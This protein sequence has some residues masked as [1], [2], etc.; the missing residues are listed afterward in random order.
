MTKRQK[1]CGGAVR[2]LRSGAVSFRASAT[3]LGLGIM[4]SL[5]ACGSSRTQIQRDTRFTEEHAKVFEDG[6]DFVTDPEQ[7][8]GRWRKEWSRE[9]DKRVRFSDAIARVTIHTL[10][11]DISPKGG[12]TYRLIAEV[13]KTFVG[14]LPEDEIMLTVSEGAR[15]YPTIEGNDD[16]I[17]QESY[18]VF[19]KWYENEDGKVAP[20]WH[21]SPT[22]EPV[23][24]RLKWLIEDRRD[25]ALEDE[26]G[27]RRVII[28]RD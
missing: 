14:S 13:D 9:I 5:S 1:V 6:V 8:G 24:E 19:I 4:A 22:N 12:S 11:T 27:R 28:R 15:G 21:L 3:V 20:H 2:S 18:F 17:L 26:G 7:L 23:A 25:V 16:R 10:R